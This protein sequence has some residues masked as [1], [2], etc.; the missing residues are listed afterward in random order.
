[1]ELSKSMKKGQRP[2]K[3]VMHAMQKMAMCAQ[4]CATQWSTCE[5]K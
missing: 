5:K 4:S 2:S 3:K 1:M